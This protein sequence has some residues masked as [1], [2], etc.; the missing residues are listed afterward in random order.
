MDISGNGIRNLIETQTRNTGRKIYSKT[1]NETEFIQ[2]FLSSEQETTLKIP[3]KDSEGHWIGGPS[4]FYDSEEDE[5]YLYYR[6]R[7]PYK[8]GWKAVIARVREGRN[9][10]TVTEFYS[11]NF[12]A[13]S[14]EGGTLRKEDGQYVLYI[15]YH[16]KSAGRWKIDRIKADTVSELSAEK[17]ENFELPV[18]YTHVKDPVIADGELVV[19]TASRY[20]NR[21]SNFVVKNIKSDVEVEEVKFSEESSPGRIT[22]T[23]E[24][25]GEKFYFYDWLKSIIFTGEEKTK[26]GVEKDG[27]IQ[28]ILPGLKA[29]GSE[30]GTRSLRYIKNIEIEDEIWFFYEKSMPGKGHKL[31]LNKMETSEVKKELDRLTK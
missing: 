26:I 8:R 7:N 6:L 20:F 4:S 18:N 31:C 16:E 3:E 22:S 1:F 19:H 9:L 5:L 24:L 11:K 25:D 14:L 23:L 28:S 21:H 17:R 13:H 30:T 15:S 29:V 2:N 27:E 12:D 10:E